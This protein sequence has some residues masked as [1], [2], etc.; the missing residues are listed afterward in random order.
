MDAL[1]EEQV[2]ECR[3]AFNQF[4]QN[5]NGKLTQKELGGVMRELGLNPTEEELEEMIREVCENEDG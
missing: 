5:E 3:E 1:T 2:N 4:C